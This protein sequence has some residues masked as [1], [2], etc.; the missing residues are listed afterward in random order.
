VCDQPKT[1]QQRLDIAGRFIEKHEYKIHMVVDTMTNSFQQTFAAW[2]FRFFVIH[3]RQVALK[4]QPHE[5]TYAYN[6][7]DLRKWLTANL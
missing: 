6:L 3:N 7:A 5:H 2:P 4:A 1:L